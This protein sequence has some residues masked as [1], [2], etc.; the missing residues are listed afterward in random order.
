MTV[1]EAYDVIC[2]HIAASAAAE[3]AGWD[4]YPDFSESDWSAIEERLV[5]RFPYP[6]SERYDTAYALLEARVRS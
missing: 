2:D 6:V 3:G 4:S 5:K 1:D